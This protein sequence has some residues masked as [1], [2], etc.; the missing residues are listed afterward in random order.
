MADT[1]TQDLNS[2][3]NGTNTSNSTYS[4]PKATLGKDDFMKLLLTELQYQDP[5]DPM[6]SDK[7]LTQTSELATLE[8]ADNTNKAMEELVAQ[9][10]SSQDFSSISAIGKM[11]SLGTDSITLQKG[12]STSFDV[13]FQDKIKSGTL[14]ISDNNGNVVRTVSLDDLEGKQGVLSFKWDGQNDS[15]EQLN[16]GSYH[17]KADYTNSDG[18]AKQ[19]QYGVYP[20]ESVKFD[21]GKAYMKL[22]SSYIPQTQIVE[23]F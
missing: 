16:P 17:V 9:M 14:D 4:N 10:K 22:G 15:G 18:E 8:S 5:T 19:T 2:V 11:A 3:A 1:I 13:Y 21:G 12:E 7:I 20:V 6:D 23:Y